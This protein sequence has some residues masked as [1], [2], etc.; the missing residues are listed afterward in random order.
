[1]FGYLRGKKRS[2]VASVVAALATALG[3]VVVS[4]AGP[5]LADTMVIQDTNQGTGVGQ[6]QFSA[7][8]N[9]CTTTCSKAP[10]NSYRWTSTAG[11]TA[12]VRFSGSQ[13]RLFGVKEP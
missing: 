11:S 1:M 13:I 12:T 7:N 6:V 3:A 5:A 9:L 4:T 10:D 8:W 2:F